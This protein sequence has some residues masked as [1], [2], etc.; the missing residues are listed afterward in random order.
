M[1]DCFLGRHQR[2]LRISVVKR[3]LL[4]LEM[5]F[6]IEILDLAADR[7][8]QPVKIANLKLRDSAATLGK[9]FDGFGN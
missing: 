5:L 4:P 8:V 6:G 2:K 9:S 7:D 1:S 3:Q